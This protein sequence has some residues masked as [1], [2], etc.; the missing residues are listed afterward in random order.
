MSGSSI[1][2]RR[3]TRRSLESTAR[4]GNSGCRRPLLPPEFFAKPERLKPSVGA[5]IGRRVSVRDVLDW[6]A[7][8]S[9]SISLT[10]V[11]RRGSKVIHENERVRRARRLEFFFSLVGVAG[12]ARII[13]QLCRASRAIAL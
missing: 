11:N 5:G 13:Q 9:H 7:S 1:M 6:G 2:Q 8:R 4:F 12:G 10:G 3:L